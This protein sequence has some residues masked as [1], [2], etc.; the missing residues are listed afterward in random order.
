MQ[1][2]IGDNLDVLMSGTLNIP[3]VPIFLDLIYCILLLLLPLVLLQYYSTCPVLS[4]TL[5]SE[6]PTLSTSPLPYRTRT[7]ASSPLDAVKKPSQ[8]EMRFMS[9]LALLTS[10]NLSSARL[11][12]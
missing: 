4:C 12:Y 11:H 1:Q 2:W 9:E 5:L 7:V 10:S 3:E 8:E 6:T